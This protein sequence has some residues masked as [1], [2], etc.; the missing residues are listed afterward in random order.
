M[1][2]GLHTG[3]VIAGSVGSARRMKYT[4]VGDTVNTAA[5]IESF[6]QGGVRGGGRARRERALPRAGERGDARRSSATA[7]PASRSARTCCAVAARRSVSTACAT[8]ARQRRPRRTRE[9]RRARRSRRGSR[10]CPASR[11]SRRKSRALVSEHVRAVHW[12]ARRAAARRRRG[13]RARAARGPPRR[14]PARAGDARRAARAG[15]ALRRRAAAQPRTC[16]C[17]RRARASSRGCPRRASSACWPPI[18]AASAALVQRVARFRARRA[19]RR[20][21]LARLFPGLDGDAL[22]ALGAGVD[23]VALRGGD[24]LFREGEPGDAAWLLISGRLRAVQERDGG[25]RALNE[26]AAGETVGEM[27]LLSDARALGLGLRGA[28][29]PARQALAARPSRSSRT[30][31]RPRCAASRASSSTGCGATAEPARV[32][33][34]GIALAVVAARAD[35]DLAG[36]R[37]APGRRARRA[38]Q[39][40]ARDARAAWTRCSDAA[41]SRTRATP[42]RPACASCA[43]STSATPPATS[44]CTRATRPGARGPSGSR[45]TPTACWSSRARP[46]APALGAARASGSRPL[47]RGAARR[48]S[49]AGP[50]ARPDGA[51]AARARGWRIAPRASTT[52]CATATR[53]DVAR[54][55]PLAD[56]PRHR[57][58]ARRRRRARLR[59]PRRAAGARGSG[60]ARSIWVGGT[61][62]GSIIAALPAQGLD[63]AASPRG[64]PPLHLVRS[65]TRRCRW[66][67]CWPDGASAAASPR[68]WA[69]ADIEDLWLPYFCV[70]TNLSRAEALVQRRGSLFRAVRSSISLP[71][72][73]PPVT[74]T[75]RCSSTAGCSTTCRSTSCRSLSGGG[76]VIAVDVSPDVDLRSALELESELSGWRALWQRVRP[77]GKRLDL[78]YISSVLMRSALVGSIV[79]DRER[80]AAETAS[81]YLKLP[82]DGLGPARVREARRHRRARL[83]GRCVARSRCGGQAARSAARSEAQP[84]EDQRSHRAVES[85]PWWRARRLAAGSSAR[86]R[87]SCS[88]AAAPI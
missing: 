21:H 53:G 68:C 50:A 29:Q 42:I 76:P 22:Q 85:H 57:A 44:C 84:S 31:I 7:S 32:P 47:W 49:T 35:V 73:L 62:I 40:A 30:G 6:A 27:A 11:R 80:R 78:P 75:A 55:R 81:L 38:R 25:E 88:G 67:R 28:R 82:V 41:A 52:T 46:T 69:A 2:I 14:H 72:I 39:R 87:I 58:R 60:R 17:G 51:R 24:W 20:V 19:A 71:G 1:R 34:A 56:R 86:C 61:S 15:R 9:R 4:T 13:R 66:S 3:E 74:A 10:R 37:G 59:A 83:P 48:R 18:R 45:A 64:L 43:G 79:G 26:I 33:R 8:S 23:W 36:V 70:A 16:G 65:S 77:F 5:R 63:A 54:R 12:E